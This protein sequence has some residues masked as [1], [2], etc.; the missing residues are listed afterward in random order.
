MGSDVV[1]EGHVQRDEGFDL[2][3][4][5]VDG[6][7]HGRR[8]CK[9]GKRASCNY[10]GAGFTYRDG[11]DLIT[12]FSASNAF[13]LASADDGPALRSLLLGVGALWT[14]YTHV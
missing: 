3:V 12:S 8:P 14:T 4:H 1:H 9:T 6:H 2:V 5:G 7:L 13:L 10:D 11:I